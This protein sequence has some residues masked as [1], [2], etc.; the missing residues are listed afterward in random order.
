ML[1]PSRRRGWKRLSIK[2]MTL[3]VFFREGFRRGVWNTKGGRGVCLSHWIFFF[4]FFTSSCKMGHHNVRWHFKKNPEKSVCIL[5]NFALFFR[6]K[7]PADTFAPMCQCIKLLGC[8]VTESWFNHL[9]SPENKAHSFL[10]LY[11]H[12]PHFLHKWFCRN[13]IEIW[14]TVSSATLTPCQNG[15]TDEWSFKKGYWFFF[16]YCWIRS[17]QPWTAAIINY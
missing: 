4:L 11:R 17:C 8:Y 12:L 2:S 1:L 3:R 6:W 5:F 9:T 15:L 13:V 7:P 14:K 16:I 10:Y